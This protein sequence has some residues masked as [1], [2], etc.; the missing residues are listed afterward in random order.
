MVVGCACV[1]Q[2]GWQP[3]LFFFFTLCTL[4]PL[5]D[6]VPL[7]HC[8]FCCF[9]KP[10]SGGDPFWEHSHNSSS[11]VLAPAAAVRPTP[12][13][14]RN[15]RTPAAVLHCTTPP[16]P[17]PVVAAAAC[18]QTC[19]HLLVLL[20]GRVG[21]TGSC[22]LCTSLAHKAAAVQEHQLVVVV[23]LLP[24]ANN[25]SSSS[26]AVT[27]QSCLWCGCRWVVDPQLPC[28]VACLAGA[29]DVWRR[30]LSCWPWSL[31]LICLSACS[32]CCSHVCCWPNLL[33]VYPLATTN[34]HPL[35]S[36]SE[37][38]RLMAWHS[39]PLLVLLLLE[40]QGPSA[41]G[42]NS[43][44]AV[45]G[46]LASTLA[47][48]AAALAAQLSAELPA[49]HLWHVKGLRYLYQDHLAAAVRCVVASGLCG[50]CCCCCWWCRAAA[51]CS[52]QTTSC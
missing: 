23:V 16:A 9:I 22:C 50:R 4:C 7:L 30:L 15:Q 41:A 47:A 33:C 14:S 18:S 52:K 12:L 6:P 8:V 17:R 20:R 11:R 51:V 29:E 31:D 44:A 45:V 37:P 26:S 49:K 34:P 3:A 46:S 36:G 25:Y 38:A 21:L 19:C 27:V 2:H 48:P 1:E 10:C 13:S 24:A 5:S 35:Q 40:P 32:T 39:G 43:T 28:C 42:S